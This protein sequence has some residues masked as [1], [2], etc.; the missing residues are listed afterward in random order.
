M[1]VMPTTEEVLGFTNRWYD[2]ALSDPIL[3]EPVPSVRIR[4]INH[5]AFLATKF[6]AF[7]NR[8][9][10]EYQGNTDIE[11]I[12]S[13]LAYCPD[14]AERIENAPR[15]V[16]EYLKVSALELLALRDLTDLISAALPAD[17]ISQSAVP[18]VLETLR[19]MS[20]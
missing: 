19:L 16:R 13:V 10:G 4:V 20:E 11:D 9:R 5:V 8:G 17:R 1:D 15:P 7:A 3:L 6:E 12:L 14:V 18:A 2:F